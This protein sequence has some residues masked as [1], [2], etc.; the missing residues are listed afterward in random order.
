MQLLK[1]LV[2]LQYDLCVSTSTTLF[3]HCD[4]P[5]PIIRLSFIISA[6]ED[7]FVMTFCPRLTQDVESL[8]EAWATT[9]AATTA[10]DGPAIAA[11]E[12]LAAARGIFCASRA[13]KSK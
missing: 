13:E 3:L 5:V 7:C 8:P 1:S 11:M 6:V 9:A 2:L 4:Q 10:V 12:G